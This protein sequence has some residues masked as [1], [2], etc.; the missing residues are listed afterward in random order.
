MDRDQLEKMTKEY[1]MLQDQ[2]QALVMQKEQFTSQKEEYKDALAELEKAKGKIYLAVGGV[3]VDTSK[4]AAIKSIKEKQDSAE[5]RLT[6]TGKQI[7]ELTKKEQ[8]LRSEITAA[9][10]ELGTNAA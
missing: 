6:I 3:M 8:T 4:D 9:L 2:L 5:L 1:Q 10:K 7:E